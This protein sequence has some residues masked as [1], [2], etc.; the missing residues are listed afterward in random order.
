MPTAK[1]KTLLISH[2]DGGKLH[3]YILPGQVN[4]K[5]V[6]FNPSLRVQCDRDTRDKYPTWSIFALPTNEISLV[7][8]GTYYKSITTPPEIVTSVG[9]VGICRLNWGEDYRVILEPESK[10]RYLKVTIGDP[11]IIPSITTSS[12]MYSVN[13]RPPKISSGLYHDIAN[14]T[15]LDIKHTVSFSEIGG[16]VGSDSTSTSSSPEV[17]SWIDQLIKDE[18]IDAPT[19][20]NDGFFMS[21][22]DWKLLV[23]NIKRHTNT[24]ITGPAGTGKTSCVR[25]VAEKIG[26]P[27]YIFDM[28]AMI[29]PIS[30][31][32]GVHRLKEGKSVFDYAQFTK[33]VQEPCII[34]LDEI[35]RAPMGVGNI[36]FPCLDDR[37][38]LPVEI[39]CGEEMRSISIHPEVTFVATANIGA[40]YTGTMTIDR[41]LQN[42][43]FPLE[44]DH[45]PKDI[46]KQ[47]LIERTGID[48]KLAEDIVKVANDIRMMHK[49]VEVSSGVSIRETLMISSLITDGWKLGEAMKAV[50]LPMYEGT[51]VEGERGL[52]FKLLASY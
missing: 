18:K 33:A 51:Q 11:R 44:L 31:L 25:Q 43:F 39:A 15:I 22:K 19:P 7:T 24:L 2:F 41:A 16:A 46:E 30:S 47:V 1:S 20:K 10:G 38:T 14:D 50:F 36:L 52:L 45:L 29:D 8:S 37:R 9:G 34:L 23:R 48:K 12:F 13:A 6:V 28:G 42:R 32:L 40:E 21:V 17:L 35:N 5:G 26:L 27:L 4:E 3:M 49:K